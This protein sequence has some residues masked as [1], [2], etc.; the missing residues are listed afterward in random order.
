MNHHS[1]FSSFIFAQLFFLT[2]FFFS[3]SCAIHST[4]AKVY[5]VH[6]IHKFTSLLFFSL[7]FHFPFFLAFLF[8]FYL[9]LEEKLKQQRLENRKSLILLFFK[10]CFVSLISLL[11]FLPLSKCDILALTAVD[12]DRIFYLQ[13]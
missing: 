3:S 13:N 1:I 11:S 7:D 6:F 10:N 9:M 8:T 5:F 2:V 12:H 4:K